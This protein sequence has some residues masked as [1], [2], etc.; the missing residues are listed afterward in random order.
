MGKIIKLA[1]ILTVFCVLSAAGLVCVYIFTQPKITANA[2]AAF[3]KARLEV[4]GSTGSGEAIT[5]APRGYAGPIN[6]LVGV[7]K[8]KVVGVKI[9]NHRETPGLGNKIVKPEFLRQFAGK[10]LTDPIEPKKDIDAITG[11][12]ISSR[13]VSKGVREA[14]DNNKP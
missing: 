3:E 6:M 7:D 11:A 10:T 8:A 1:L 12:T 4:L 9:L 5:V 2:K 13:A 14:L